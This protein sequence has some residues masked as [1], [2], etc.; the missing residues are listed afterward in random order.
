MMLTMFGVSLLVPNAFAQALSPFVKIV[1]IATALLGATQIFGGII[2]SALIAFAPDINQMP[3]G[4]IIAGS[5]MMLFGLLVWL[6]KSK[7]Q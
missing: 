4:I 3:L 5:G 6:K 2:T 7:F 1:G